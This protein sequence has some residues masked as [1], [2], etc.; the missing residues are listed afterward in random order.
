MYSLSYGVGAVLFLTTCFCICV[1]QH[2]QKEKMPVK[3]NYNK[4]NK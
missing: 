4:I 1:E 2:N 3:K